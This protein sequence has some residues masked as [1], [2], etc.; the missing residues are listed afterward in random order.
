MN[1]YNPDAW[2]VIKISTENGPL[3]KVFGT[4][5]GGYVQSESWRLNSGIMSVRKNGKMLEFVG[6]SGSVYGVPNHEHCYRTT[7]YSGS[8]LANLIEKSPVEIQVLPFDTNWE[9]LLN[10]VA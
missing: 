10:E 6:H 9:E 7:A 5:Y 3:Y 4:W 2:Q 8:V 1:Q